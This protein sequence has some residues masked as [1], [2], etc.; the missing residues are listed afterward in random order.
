[1]GDNLQKGQGGHAQ[2]HLHPLTTLIRE[3]SGIFVSM[4]FEVADGPEIEDEY[5]NFDALNVPKDHPARDM[6]DTF[7]VKGKEGTVL[8]THTSPVQ[9]RYMETHKPPFNIIVPGKVFRHEATD[10]MHE[11]QFYQIEGL[12]VGKDISLAHLKGVLD[13]FLKK[14][15]GDDIKI[16]LRPGYFPFVEPGVEIDMRCARCKGHGCSSCKGSGWIEV[17]GAGMVHPNVLNNVGVD[18]REWSGFAFG[19]GIDRL[20]MLKYGIPDVRMLYAGDL[21]LVDQF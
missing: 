11:L 13:T 20:V 12:A 5:H 10:V 3:V 15:F 6:Q 16:K 17:L 21:R 2:G 19:V 9:I 1:M 7:W 8:R 14:L 4:G 18:P